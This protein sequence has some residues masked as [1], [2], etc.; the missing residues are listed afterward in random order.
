MQPRPPSLYPFLA[1][2]L[3]IEA[4][5]IFSMR[6]GPGL[7]PDSIDYVA[8]AESLMHGQGW[9][10]LNGPYLEWPP[11]FPMVIATVGFLTGKALTG[12]ILVNAILLGFTFY[13][14]FHTYYAKLNDFWARLIFWIGSVF[15]IPVL[16]CHYFIWSE[17]VFICAFSAFLFFLRKP[18]SKGIALAAFFMMMSRYAGLF[19]IIGERVFAFVQTPKHWWKEGL[20]RYS[21]AFLGLALWLAY[22]YSSHG[23]LHSERGAPGFSFGEITLAVGQ[24]GASWFLPIPNIGSYALIAL[25]LV[26]LPLLLWSKVRTLLPDES[27][28]PL[29]IGSYMACLLATFFITAFNELPD[30][31]LLSPIYLPLIGYVALLVNSLEKQPWSTRAWLWRI[32]ALLWSAYTVTRVLK[33]VYSFYA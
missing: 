14:H 19:F 18:N 8:C 12:A 29:M 17:S 11:L 23:M 2:L 28:E 26:V 31:R 1:G 3:L 22:L 33:N 24:V 27:P 30:E 15:A 6:Q 20:I 13:F 16:L 10:R 9:R 7:S 5:Y 21:L 25:M 4:L 32:P